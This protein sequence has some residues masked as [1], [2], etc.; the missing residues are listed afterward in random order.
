[1]DIDLIDASILIIRPKQAFINWVNE[2]CKDIDLKTLTIIA[3]G[4]KLYGVNYGV[5]FSTAP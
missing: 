5:S 2:Q 1:M 4:L 3:L